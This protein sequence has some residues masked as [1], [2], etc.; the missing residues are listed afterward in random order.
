MSDILDEAREKEE[1][2][3]EALIAMALGRMEVAQPLTHC[4]D[5]GSEIPEGRRKASPSARRCIGCQEDFE[6]A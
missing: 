2:E 6:G 5:C 3:R 4:I 1:C